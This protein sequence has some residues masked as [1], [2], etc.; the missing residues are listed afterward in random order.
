MSEILALRKVRKTRL[1]TSLSYTYIARS[2]IK[3]YGRTIS[4]LAY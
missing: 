2:H 4:F 3:E 1:K